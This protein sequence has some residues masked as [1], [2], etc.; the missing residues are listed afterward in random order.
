MALASQLII[1]IMAERSSQLWK[2][3]SQQLK[4]LDPWGLFTDESKFHTFYEHKNTK[5]FF[6]EGAL[7]RK[8][9]SMI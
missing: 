7:L 2:N 4:L 3:G 1:T 6:E 8:Q 9:L 5:L